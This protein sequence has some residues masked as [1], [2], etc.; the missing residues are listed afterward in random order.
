MQISAQVSLYPLRQ[1]RLSP[2]IEAALR[3]LEEK[4]LDVEKGA[5]SSTVSGEADQV[6]D[7]IK[8]AF[9]GSAE[10]GQVS[11]VVTFSNACPIVLERKA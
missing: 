2:S 6:F 5:M 10:K 7:A 1:E 8:E 11:M 4:Q 9:L 3:I